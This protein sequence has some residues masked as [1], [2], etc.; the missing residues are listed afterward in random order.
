MSSPDT[1]TPGG[2][3]DVGPETRLAEEKVS[4]SRQTVSASS[5]PVTM[6]QPCRG[7]TYTGAVRTSAS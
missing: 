7:S 1:S 5:N 3:G 4:V 2:K 6:A